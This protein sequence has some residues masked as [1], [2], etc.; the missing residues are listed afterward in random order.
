M[1]WIK[2]A[3]PDLPL[4]GFYWLSALQCAWSGTGVTPQCHCRDSCTLKYPF[5]RF[6]L[7]ALYVYSW[8]GQHKAMCTIYRC[9]EK[10]R[11]EVFI[12]GAGGE[13]KELGGIARGFAGW[14]TAL[15]YLRRGGRRNESSRSLRGAENWEAGFRCGQCRE[16]YSGVQHGERNSM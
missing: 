5:H 2:N 12:P 8:N 9:M 11:G 10:K 1:L 13:Q 3:L 15:W 6:L 4:L 16:S 14:H 7:P